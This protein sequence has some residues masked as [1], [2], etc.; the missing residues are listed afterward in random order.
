M[1]TI[2]IIL[3]TISALMLIEGAIIAIFPKSTLKQIR[4][5]FKNTKTTIKIGLIEIILA[6]IILF[7][8]SI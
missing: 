2:E 8:I 7:I 3:I 1:G 5:I 4:K 6:L